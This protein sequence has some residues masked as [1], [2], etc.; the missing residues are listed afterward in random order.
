MATDATVGI[1]RV[2]LTANSAEFETAMKKAADSAKVWSKDLA[3]IGAQASSVGLALTKTLTLPIIGIGAAAVKM[4][5]DF[6]GAMANVATLI[7]GNVD[8]VNELKN[9]VQDMAVV[10]GKST[11]DLADG[12]YQVISAFG[13]GAETAKILDINARA[14]AAGLAS[15]TDAINLTSAVTKGYGDTSAEAVQKAAD[16]A[17][18]TVKLGQTTFPELSSAIGKVIPIAAALNVSQEELFAG[19]ATLTGVTGTAAEVTTQMRGVMAALLKPTEDMQKALKALGIESSAAAIEQLGLVG[20]VKQ[21]ISTTDGSTEAIGKLF[22]NVESLPAVFALTSGQ[23]EV[24]DEKLKQVK[25]SSG[26]MAEAFLEQSEGVNAAG[27]A[28]AQFTQKMAVATQRIGDVLLPVLMRAGESLMPFLDGLLKLVSAFGSLPQ[29]AQTTVI[30][31]GAVL[32]AMGPVLFVTGQLITALGTVVGA[33]TAKGIAMRALQ[34]VIAFYTTQM[35]A[36]AGATT[37]LRTSLIGLVGIAGGVVAAFGSIAAAW[38]S[39]KEDWTRAFDVLIPPIGFL[40][41]GIDQLGASN[42]KASNATQPL[43][44]DMKMIASHGT[45]A[46]AAVTRIVTASTGF[47]EELARARQQVS[48]LTKDQRE[49]ILAGDA[50][51]KSTSEIATEMGLSEAVVGLFKEQVAASTA[52]TKKATDEQKKF[53][54]SVA[55]L[56]ASNS[57]PAYA[58]LLSNVNTEIGETEFWGKS[59]TRVFDEQARALGVLSPK[60]IELKAA[61]SDTRE[62]LE[63][64]AVS[65]TD[66][67]KQL[68]DLAQSLGTLA[69]VSGGTFRGIVQQIATVIAALNAGQKAGEAM[70]AGLAQMRGGNTSSGLAS[71]A[72][73]ALGAASALG[74]AT[75][76]GGT[77]SRTVSGMATGAKIGMAFGPWGAAIGAAAGAVVGLVRGLT[78]VSEAV[79]QSRKEVEE[80]QQ[81]I[82][83]SATAQQVSQAA[84]QSWRLTVITVRD[85]FIAAG[86]SAEEAERLVAQMWNTDRPEA[87]RQAML[88]INA[89]LGNQRLEQEILNEAIQEYGFSID[90]LGPRMR[91]QRLSEQAQRLTEH[92]AVLAEAQFDV[93]TMAERM[94]EKT[95]EYLSAA[96]TTG[97]EVPLAMRPML[98]KM[99]EMGLLT[100]ENG[101]KL[102]DLGRIT[103]A[104]T[105]TQGFDRVVGAV[106]RLIASLS[107]IPSQI[108]IDVVGTYIPPEIPGHDS[109]GGGLDIPHLAAGGIVTAP[110]LALIGERGPEAVVPLSASGNS[111]GMNFSAM[112]EELR[113]IRRALSDLPGDIKIAYKGALAGV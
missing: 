71:I 43:L 29:P 9:S 90:E 51:G 19:F 65:T 86:R 2:L 60:F 64:V 37:A 17:F 33:F 28:W 77:L 97:A 15:T 104:E 96:L 42:E 45:Q 49:A 56:N 113:A 79:K 11:G 31:L 39:Y 67:D 44:A 47:R 5:T 14:A 38:A 23:A 10:T 94:S 57:L 8:R 21:V 112:H 82:H 102:T 84:G 87:A 105:M 62:G 26:A 40:R 85:A 36:A 68:G 12:L 98:E 54:Q 41:I 110:T 107:G 73:G 78:S 108:G 13:D 50:L 18:V 92:W 27:F 1:L 83:A 89:V 3:A 106:E 80:F 48:A 72:T 93:G 103:W 59:I 101:E 34:P 7:P 25:N 46:A 74:Q 32:A 16:L 61:V 6:N 95:N 35:T 91:A 4:S 70:A 76:H 88:A 63:D 55:D 22:A 81:A 58:L 24:F 99:L 20:T 53:W 69:Q 100:D 52:A 30:A 75:A 109:T 111:G 66:W